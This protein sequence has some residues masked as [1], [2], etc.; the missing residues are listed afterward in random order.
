MTYDEVSNK[1]IMFL[2]LISIIFNFKPLFSFDIN[3]NGQSI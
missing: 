1:D 2:S 3:H